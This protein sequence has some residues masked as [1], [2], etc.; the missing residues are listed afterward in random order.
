MKKLIAY[1]GLDCEKC[2]ARKATLNND[3][4]LRE[5]TAKLW[6]ELNNTEIT[7]EMINCMGCR[8]D[9]IKTVYCDSLCPIRKCAVSKGFETCGECQIV[10]DCQIIAPITS[11]NAEAKINLKKEQN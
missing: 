8:T 4:S 9:G 3:N 1:C 2:D 10:E 6:S 7:A 5:K 11:T